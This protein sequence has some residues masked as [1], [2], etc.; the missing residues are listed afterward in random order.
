MELTTKFSEKQLITLAVISLMLLMDNVDANIIGTA[1]PTIAV[2]LHTSALNLKLAVTSYLIS[3]AIF[4]PIG[5]WV[6]DK[7]GTKKVLLMSVMFFVIFSIS[8]ASSR[9]LTELVVFRFFQGIAGAFMAPVGRLLLLK[10]FNKSDMVRVYTLMAM[11]VILGPLLAPLIGGALIASFGWRYIFWVNVPM[12]LFGMWATYYYVENYTGDT[13]K[14][15][16]W[17]FICLGIFL[18]VFSFW[19]DVLF[20]PLSLKLKLLLF[21]C[22]I[23]ALVLYCIIEFSSSNRIVNYDIFKYRIFRLCFYGNF[24]TR[25]AFGGRT[26]A[27]A[28]YL[29]MCLHMTPLNAG[30]LLSCLAPGLFLGRVFINRLL[31]RYGFQK[32]MIVAN[33]GVTVSTLLLCFI[34]QA[35][36]FAV[37]I[38]FINGIFSSISYMLLNVLSFAET[39]EADYAAASSISNTVQQLSLSIGVVVCASSLNMFNHVFSEFSHGVFNATFILLAGLGILTQLLFRRL[40]PDDGANLIKQKTTKV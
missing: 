24:M 26:F 3:L 40:H 20:F 29:Q 39:S 8:C 32:M 18:S 9:S 11:P 12:G 22:A 36:V 13:N 21:M 35:D 6:S 14:F 25:V 30:Y 17:S 34:T 33:I 15:N 4:I 31:P 10:A 16:W 7:F 37:I 27:L 1:I 5:G 23:V 19:L 28:L 38:I 2:S